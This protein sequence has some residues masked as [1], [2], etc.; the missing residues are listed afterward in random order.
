MLIAEVA[1]LSAV[2]PSVWEN[3]TQRWIADVN[4]RVNELYPTVPT[5]GGPGPGGGE[6]PVTPDP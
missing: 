6:L 4:R 2:D 3:F 1:A 5:G